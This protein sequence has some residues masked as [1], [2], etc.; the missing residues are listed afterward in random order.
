MRYALL[1]LIFPSIALGQY[2]AADSFQR[3]ATRERAVAWS[4]VHCRRFIEEI[5][6]SA[7]LACLAC[8]PWNANRLAQFHYSGQLGRLPDPD[9]ILLAIAHNGDS[10]AWFV[11]HHAQELEEPD[12]CSAFLLNPAEYALSLKTLEQGAT[13]VRASKMAQYA[14]AQNRQQWNP[15]TIALFL[16]L[17]VVAGLIAWRRKRNQQ[18]VI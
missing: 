9:R 17:S 14:T 16:G 2:S 1:L 6:D 8:S 11:I 15:K 3:R 12:E 4:G 10:V 18:S 13:E 5:G 7:A